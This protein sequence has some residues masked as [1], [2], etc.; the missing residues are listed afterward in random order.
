MVHFAK[1]L[2]IAIILLTQGGNSLEMRSFQAIVAS[3]NNSRIE[4]FFLVYRD[5]F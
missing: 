5:L 4:I 2:Q 1:T 3:L